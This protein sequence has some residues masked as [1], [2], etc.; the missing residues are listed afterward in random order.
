MKL[1]VPVETVASRRLQKT[2]A[3]SP[4]GGQSRNRH[5]GSLWSDP[6]G[7]LVPGVADSIGHGPAAP[8]QSGFGFQGARREGVGPPPWE[9]AVPSVQCDPYLLSRSLMEFLTTEM[10][11]A[12]R[13]GTSDRSALG[14][15]LISASAVTSP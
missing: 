5:R 14:S 2:V 10:G 12:G 6:L 3:V 4:T 13:R 7:A 11:F 9:E 1:S 15:L 8:S